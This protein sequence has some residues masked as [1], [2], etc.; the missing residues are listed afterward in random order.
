MRLAF[1]FVIFRNFVVNT[2]LFK[3]PTKK[4]DA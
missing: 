3:L 4:T 2:E 1:N